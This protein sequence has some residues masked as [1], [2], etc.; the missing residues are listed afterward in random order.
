M[1]PTELNELM[2]QLKVLLDKGFYSTKH[3][4]MGC[5][6]NVYDEGRWVTSDVYRLPPIKQ[7]HHDE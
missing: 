1:A 6:R 5:P 2:E 7:S 4:S 3:I